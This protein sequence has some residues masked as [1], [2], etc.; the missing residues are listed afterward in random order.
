MILGHLTVTYSVAV[1]IQKRFPGL[2][3]MGGVLLGA[4]L[5]DILD[6]PVSFIWGTPSR[7]AGH[8]AV[9]MGLVIYILTAALPARR[10]LIFSVG[11]GILLHLL[12]DMVTLNQLLWPLLGPWT[13]QPGAGLM[14]KLLNYYVRFKS[15]V[16]FLVE[17]ASYPFFLLF[18]FR[19]FRKRRN[20]RR[21]KSIP[22]V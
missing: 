7:G 22:G 9:V 16:P 3:V 1:P 11:A 20:E 5:P 15:P 14:E 17:A 4:L 13:Y 6:K 10:K 8:S 18:T 12:E 2:C 21:E 19:A